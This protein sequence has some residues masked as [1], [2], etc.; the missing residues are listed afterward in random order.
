LRQGADDRTGGGSDDQRDVAKINLSL[1]QPSDQARLPS[2]SY[3][4]AGSEHKRPRAVGAALFV[5]VVMI[6]ERL[7]SGFMVL[8]RQA[9]WR[10]E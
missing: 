3:G 5:P 8:N 9:S 4:A 6:H 2:S 10:R 7:P 1:D